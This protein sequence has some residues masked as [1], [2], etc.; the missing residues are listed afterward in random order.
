MLPREDL[1][2]GLSDAG[3]HV[4]QLCDAG[5]ATELLGLW[6]RERQALSLERAVRKLTGEVSDL[7]NLPGRGYLR[8]GYA[9]DISI[10]DPATVSAGPTRRVADFPGGAS[11]LVADRPSGVVHVLVNGTPIR[12]D[13][14]SQMEALERRPGMVVRSTRS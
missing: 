4:G 12:L 14:Q 9:A 8:P 2:L 11:R 6:V 5:F 7:F 13:G 10:F 1:I 3:A